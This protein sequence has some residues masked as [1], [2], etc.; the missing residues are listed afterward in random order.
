M[1]PLGAS[2]P[3]PGLRIGPTACVY[4][5]YAIIGVGLFKKFFT[6]QKS[7]KNALRNKEVLLALSYFEYGEMMYF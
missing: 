5:C 4:A 1:E 2:T 3:G 7:V 6:N